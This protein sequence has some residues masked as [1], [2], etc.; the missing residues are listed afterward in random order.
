VRES[1]KSTGYVEVNGVRTWY[2]E[3]GAGDALV[4]LHGGFSDSRDFDGNLDALAQ[5]FRLFGEGVPG[6]GSV[7]TGADL[8]RQ[9]DPRNPPTRAGAWPSWLAANTRIVHA[10]A[11]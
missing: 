1:S 10:P 8:S 6:D 11:R 5:R 2:G 9:R 4:L 3:R 7:P